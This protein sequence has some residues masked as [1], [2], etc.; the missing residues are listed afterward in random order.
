M[1]IINCIC[2]LVYRIAETRGG[3]T[4]SLAR[5]SIHIITIGL[6]NMG[7]LNPPPTDYNKVWS[8]AQKVFG[9]KVLQAE[10]F[11]NAQANR[12]LRILKEDFAMSFNGKDNIQVIVTDS[13]AAPQWIAGLPVPQSAVVYPGI[14]RSRER[15]PIPEVPNLGIARLNAVYG[16]FFAVLWHRHEVHT[17]RAHAGSASGKARF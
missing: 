13:Y 2:D 10:S 9:T 12:L 3:G 17:R 8:I 7:T 15:L 6:I 14:Q 11:H 16:L 5:R 4:L 1:R